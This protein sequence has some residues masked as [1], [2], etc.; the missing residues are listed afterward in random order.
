MGCLEDAQIFAFVQGQASDASARGVERHLEECSDCRR[1]VAET[2]KYFEDTGSDEARTLSEMTTLL[3]RCAVDDWTAP[4]S[5]GERVG[6]FIVESTIGQGATGVIYRA[7]DPALGRSIALKVLKQSESQAE[8]RLLREAQAMAQLAHPNV[9][10]VYDVIDL[11]GRWLVSM[12]L[13]EGLPLS[14]WLAAPERTW[15]EAMDAFLAAGQGLV[16]AHDKGIIH[17]DFKPANVLMGRDGRARVTDFGLARTSSAGSSFS[18]RTLTTIGAVLGTPAYMS[19]EQLTGAPVDPRTDQFSFCV[20]LYRALYRRHPYGDGPSRIDRMK[21]NEVLP[22]HKDSKVPSGVWNVLARGLRFGVE[23]RHPTM[24]HLLAALEETARRS[25]RPRLVYIAVGACGVIAVAGSWALSS[26]ARNEPTTA[27]PGEVAP[28]VA[29][30][31]I[32]PARSSSAAVGAP[33]EEPARVESS[34]SIAHAPATGQR[35]ARSPLRD[36]GRKRPPPP[37]EERRFGDG[38]KDPF[39]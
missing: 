6:R 15:R 5:P 34:R 11:D 25:S 19:P 20:A 27:A 16:A 23:E 26:H 32:A 33:P 3:G 7:V 38:L 14:E 21:R 4:L 28:Q 31:P 37:V 29:L 8:A 39:R 18:G 13:V 2:A 17:R 10:A 30:A 24:R 22:A 12:E 9:V 1:I 35:P 36:R